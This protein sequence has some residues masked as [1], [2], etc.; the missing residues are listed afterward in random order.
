MIRN[1]KGFLSGNRQNL[2]SNSSQGVTVGDL[3][4]NHQPEISDEPFLFKPRTEKLKK[5]LK[6]K[7]GESV[8]NTLDQ[9]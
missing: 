9:S 4:G 3:I 6:M 1:N 7:H 2:V 5:L 8:D